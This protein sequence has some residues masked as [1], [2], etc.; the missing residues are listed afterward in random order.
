M[1]NEK[2][3]AAIRDKIRKAGTDDPREVA[4][5]YGIL[6]IPLKGTITGYAASYLTLAV[7]GV[8]ER[9]SGTWFAFAAYHE[10]AHVFAG[11]IYDTALRESLIDNGIFNQEVDD[12]N[13][14]RHEKIANLVSADI[15]ISD[16][17]VMEETGLSSRTM[18]AYRGMKASEENLVREFER[19]RASC[20]ENRAPAI[21]RAR[22]QDLRAR[23]QSLS[24]TI[25][26]ME[27][28]MAGMNAGAS[29]YEMASDL[30]IDERIFRYKLEAMRIRG[31]D[32]DR[33]ELESYGRMFEGALDG[34]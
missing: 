26:D 33:Q 12:L 15:C 24:G 28:E 32:I 4:D 2:I 3:I 34:A 25:A 21:L 8:N 18:R 29:F 9:L 7:I 1:L 30:G 22:M 19:L 20:D 23:L 16:K 13:I 27:R 5:H 17:S 10:L 14:P 31:F 6:W 11:D